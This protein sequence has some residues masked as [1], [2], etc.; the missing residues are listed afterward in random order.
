[1]TDP[2]WLTGPLGPD[3][4]TICAGDSVRRRAPSGRA[5]R[6]IAVRSYV[7]LGGSS[8][9][10]RTDSAV[11]ASRS[12]TSSRARRRRRIDYGAR[13]C[14]VQPFAALVS[15]GSGHESRAQ[16][17]SRI[18]FSGGRFTSKAGISRPELVSRIP[19]CG[20]AGGTSAWP[21]FMGVDGPAAGACGGGRGRPRAHSR[22][23]GRS[24]TRCLYAGIVVRAARLPLP[25]C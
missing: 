16:I 19:G 20:R 9:V 24:T 13:P 17:T 10:P 21:A 5:A 18:R 3:D 8:S 1:M 2:L 22:E 11:R 23:R 14:M 15:V 25:S 7:N 12:S 4:A 6:R